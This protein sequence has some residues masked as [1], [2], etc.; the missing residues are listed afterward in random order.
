LP[1]GPLW[2]RPFALAQLRKQYLDGSR[3]EQR[4]IHR[5]TLKALE[6]AEADG[7]APRRYY[8][9]FLDDEPRPEAAVIHALNDGADQIVVLE[10]Y[11]VDTPHSAGGRQRMVDTL[12]GFEGAPPM[13]FSGPLADSPALQQLH[14]QR[15]LAMTP[16][17]ERATTGVLLVAFARSPA[18]NERFPESAAAEV[19][20]LNGAQAALEE[21]GFPLVRQARLQGEPAPINMAEELAEAGAERVLYALVTESADSDLTQRALP[22]ALARALVPEHVSLVNMGGWNDDPQLV[23]ALQA[24][25]VASQ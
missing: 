20:F 11:T 4:A 24:A 8:L 13:R 10:V 5:R 25:L 19:R 2:A 17:N 9:A 23:K 22:Q 16:S 18:W 3:S 21:A 7:G 12:A 6:S 15:A 1:A 14:A